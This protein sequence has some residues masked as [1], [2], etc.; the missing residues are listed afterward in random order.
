MKL[1]LS[2]GLLCIAHMVLAVS[3]R[4]CPTICT[5]ITGANFCNVNA[6]QLCVSNSAVIN[7]DLTVCGEIFNPGGQPFGGQYNAEIF[8]TAGDMTGLRIGDQI[9]EVSDVINEESEAIRASNNQQIGSNQTNTSSQGLEIKVS[10]QNCVSAFPKNKLLA[11]GWEMPLDREEGIFYVTIPFGAPLNIN[12]AITP[13]LDIH[14]FTS[15]RLKEGYINLGIGANFTKDKQDTGQEMELQKITG[16]LLV[17]PPTD[18][19]TIRAFTVSVPL[20]NIIMH[21]RSFGQIYIG[22]IDIDKEE[23]SEYQGSI[24]LAAANIRYRMEPVI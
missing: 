14:F 16:N 1:F 15:G 19:S 24:Y 21:P 18:P 2:F 17:S 6:Q 13:V 8:F 9:D 7:G 11:C 5:S 20:E 23:A 22:R 10:F 4:S 3:D 12:L